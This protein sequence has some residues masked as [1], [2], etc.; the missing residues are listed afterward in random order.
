MLLFILQGV[1][2]CAQ[3][4]FF[5]DKMEITS[6]SYYGKILLSILNIIIK[7]RIFNEKFV[8]KKKK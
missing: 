8:I 4:I 1:C 3:L 5:K 2:L 6:T 7:N